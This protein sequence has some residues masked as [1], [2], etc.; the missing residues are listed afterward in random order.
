MRRYMAAKRRLQT[1]NLGKAV[2]VVLRLVCELSEAATRYAE[3]SDLAQHQAR[4]Q[5]L[6]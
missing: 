4:N 6:S 2:F 5:A 1:L 3:V